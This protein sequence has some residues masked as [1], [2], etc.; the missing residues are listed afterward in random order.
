MPG[1]GRHLPP[2]QSRSTHPAARHHSQLRMTRDQIE[3]SAIPSPLL[4]GERG[5]GFSGLHPSASSQRTFVKRCRPRQRHGT[6]TLRSSLS[7]IILRDVPAAPSP[8]VPAAPLSNVK[9]RPRPLPADA[10]QKTQDATTPR[11]VDRAVVVINYHL[12]GRPRRLDPRVTRWR[13]KPGN[14]KNFHLKFEG[15][16]FLWP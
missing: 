5:V 14:E 4:G 12:K 9:T 6:W 10:C 3:V 15:K 2:A 1:C 16:P 8:R 13:S 11:G 7:T